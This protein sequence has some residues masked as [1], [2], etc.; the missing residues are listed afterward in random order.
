MK[1]DDLQKIECT[2][3]KINKICKEALRENIHFELVKYGS[4]V[5]GLSLSGQ[6]GSDLDLILVVSQ[7]LCDDL[8]N[9]MI[10]ECSILEKIEREMMK[11]YDEFTEL[12]L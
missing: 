9:Q 3:Q 4:A 5:N 6:H 11:D 8:Y 2:F 1:E 7:V 10:E 12:E